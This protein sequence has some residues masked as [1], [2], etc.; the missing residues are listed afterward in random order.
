[1]T[2]QRASTRRKRRRGLVVAVVTTVAA[3]TSGVGAYAAISSGGNDQQLASSPPGPGR[4]LRAYDLAA[5]S[6]TPVFTLKNGDTVNL[7]MGQG[8]KCLVRTLDGRIAGEL[9]AT[10]AG[11][12]EGQGISVSDECGTNSNRMMENL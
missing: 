10:N 6:A 11:I 1:M 4:A 8:A 3:V 5:S 7:F 9:C 2:I 12:A